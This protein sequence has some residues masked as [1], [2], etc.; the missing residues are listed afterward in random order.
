VRPAASVADAMAALGRDVERARRADQRSRHAR[1]R[2]YRLIRR[3]GSCPWGR[4]R[5]PSIAGRACHGRAPKVLRPASEAPRE[6]GGG[7]RTGDRG[8]PA[9]RLNGGITSR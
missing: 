5:L 2:R 4:R 8:T 9:G 3:C 6:A 1:R 7:R